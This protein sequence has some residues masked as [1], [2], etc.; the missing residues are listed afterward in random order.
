[1]L[2]IIKRQG[3]YV[4]G[5]YIAWYQLTTVFEKNKE[6]SY[7]LY[8]IS[9]PRHATRDNLLVLAEFHSYCYHG[10]IILYLKFQAII[11]ITELN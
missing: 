3:K 2:N 11:F 7:V 10:V 9:L 6:F 1:M 8:V 5:V 4:Q